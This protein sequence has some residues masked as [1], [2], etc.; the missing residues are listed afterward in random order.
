[1]QIQTG[2]ASR[3]RATRRTLI[4]TLEAVLRLL[5]PITPFITAELWERVAPVAGRAD[6]LAGGS[7]ASADY[8]LPQLDRIDADAD[9]WVTRLKAVV[10]ACRNLRAEMNLSPAERVPLMVHGDAGF[11]DQAG[12]LLKTLAKV[13]ELRRFADDNEFDRA[14]RNAPTAVHGGLRM[15]LHVEV[16]VAAELERL[17]KEIDRLGAEI[18]KADA[19][20][21][22]QSFVARAPAAVVEQERQ[23]VADFSAT[24][25]RLSEQAERLGAIDP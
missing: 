13:S 7:V 6:A 4:R 15:A 1:M 20:L 19:K 18:A 2:D 25:S 24:R 23:R 5:H 11:V 8:P 22:N 9:A 16:D 17:R 3:Q 21:G 10:G 12:P 14:S